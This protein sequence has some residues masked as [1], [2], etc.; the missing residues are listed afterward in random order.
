MRSIL[1]AVFAKNNKIFENRLTRAECSFYGVSLLGKPMMRACTV[2][3]AI[4][5]IPAAEIHRREQG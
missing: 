4:E 2:A 5:C 3:A 1:S